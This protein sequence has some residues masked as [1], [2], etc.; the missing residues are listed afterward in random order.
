MNFIC[1]PCKAAGV[2]PRDKPL[3]AVEKKALHNQCRG[4]SWC[5]CQHRVGKKNAS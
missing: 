1:T 5:D 2:I 4:G 3:F